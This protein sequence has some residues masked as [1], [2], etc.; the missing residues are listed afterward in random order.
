MRT[1]LFI[2]ISVL[3]GLQFFVLWNLTLGWQHGVVI[4]LQDYILH[5]DKK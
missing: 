3:Y 2:D 4:H 1:M 5:C